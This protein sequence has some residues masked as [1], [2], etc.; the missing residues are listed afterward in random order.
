MSFGRQPIS[1]ARYTRAA[2]R[3]GVIAEETFYQLEV[4]VCGACSLFQLVNQPPPQAMFDADYPYFTGT[5]R[6]M[7]E[8][9]RR[10]AQTLCT[11]FVHEAGRVI[12]IG[13]NDGSFLRHVAGAG[14]SHLG[15]E[16]S[17]GVA[18]VARSAGVQVVEAFFDQQ[19]AADLRRRLGPINLVYAANVIAH[20]PDVGAVGRG[21]ARLLGEDGVFV[22]EVAYLG[23]VLNNVSLD[24]IYDEHVFTFYVFARCGLELIDLEPLPVHGGSM[25]FFLAPSGRRTPSPIVAD[26]LVRERAAKFDQGEVYERF[27]RACVTTRQRLRTLLEELSADGAVIAGYGAT[28][29]STTLLNYCGLSPRYIAFISDNTPAKVGKLSPGAHIPIVL[30][31]EFRS[32]HPDYALLLAWNHRAEIEAKEQD[33]RRRGGKWILYVPEVGI[34]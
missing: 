26:Y 24:Q 3:D 33:F 32:R 22:F 23:D 8:H 11:R 6:S 25:R 2:L 27:R 30:P 7:A 18:E 31:E 10:A 4:A 34:T 17:S 13:S 20:I 19:L 15:I 1:Q 12:E 29:K 16:P 5:S 9:F 21:V 28:A 14:I